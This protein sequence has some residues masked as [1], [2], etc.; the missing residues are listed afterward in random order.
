[1]VEEKLEPEVETIYSNVIA[2]KNFLLSGGAGSGKTYCLVQT[3][4]KCIKENPTAKIACMTYTNAAVKEIEKRVNHD[5]LSVS[6][7]HDFLWDNIKAYQKELIVS[8]T[9]LINDDNSNISVPEGKIDHFYFAN[10]TDEIQYKEWTR[11]KEGII[12]HDEVLEVANVMYENNVRLCDIIKDKYKFIFIDEYQDTSPLVVEI[13]LEHL[14]KS[15]KKNIIGFFGDSM[16]AIYDGTIGDLSKY[17]SVGDVVEVQRKQNRRNPLQVINLAN[18]LRTDGLKQEQ[19][20][21]DNAPNMNGGGIKSGTITFV[22]SKSNDI[23]AIKIAIGWNF[24]DL[25]ETKELNLTHNLI[26]PKAGFLGLME[27]YDKDPV[28]GLKNDIVRKIKNDIE[29]GITYDINDTDTF[30]VVADLVKPVNQKKELKKKVLL[31]SHPDLYDELKDVPFSE[32]RKIYLDKEALIDD[33]K[34]DDSDETKKGSKRDNLIRHLFKI[35]FNI[36]LYK[37]KQYNTFLR[38]TEYQIRSIADK[39]K[40]RDIVEQ[41]DN[42]SES[43]IEEVIDFAAQEGICR[44]DDKFEQFIIDNSYLFNRVKTIKYREFQNLYNYLEGYTPFSTQHKIKGDEFKN[45]LVILDNGRWSNFN[46][47]YLFTGAGTSASVLNRTQKIF[48]VCCTRAKDNLVVFYNAPIPAV[49][50][51]AKEWFGE[52][53]VKEIN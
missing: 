52:S 5:N 49:V 38:R 16:Q 44:K 7:I 40:I 22:H 36:H 37:N 9:Q 39:V 46:F 2:G 29:R 21:D 24:N 26:A 48:Y 6:T 51:K 43:T 25:K 11:I 31:A 50:S 17:I 32:V 45:V 8:L 20:S 35:Q 33:K 23:E 28:I 27:I 4:K 13:F 41:L 47:E 12:S 1:M 42:M 18:K 14:K 30:D 15:K 34:Q 3:I 10:L 53:N 19:S